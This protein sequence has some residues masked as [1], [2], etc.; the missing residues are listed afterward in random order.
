[1]PVR[2]LSSG[3]WLAPS[4]ASEAC[5]RRVLGD[6][7]S[8]SEF[9]ASALHCRNSAFLRAF[10]RCTGR[11]C[12]CALLRGCLLPILPCEGGHGL[13]DAMVRKFQ[14]GPSCACGMTGG[15][16]RLRSRARRFRRWRAGYCDRCHA[17]VHLATAP[18]LAAHYGM[19]HDQRPTFPAMNLS[20]VSSVGCSS[21]SATSQ[22]DGARSG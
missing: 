3:S 5:F 14:E 16:P 2:V 4:A 17:A 20:N 18:V 22:R 9:A 21:S 12:R 10:P 7:T 15:A 6:L 19:P 11:P 1:M 8:A 13:V